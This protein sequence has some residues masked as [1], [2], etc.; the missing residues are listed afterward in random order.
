MSHKLLLRIILPLVTL[1]FVSCGGGGGDGDSESSSS[2]GCGTLNLKVINGEACSFGS[3]SPVALLVSQ[4]DANTVEVCTG[5][6]IT[7]TRV[8]TAAHC[9]ED[10]SSSQVVVGG[11]TYTFSKRTSHPL[12]D[13]AAGSP[14]DIAIGALPHAITTAVPVPIIT[15]TF[16]PSGSSLTVYGF[17]KTEKGDN[18]FSRDNPLFAASIDVITASDAG[19]LSA[20]DATNTSVCVGDS[21]GPALYN[22]G[23]GVGVAGVTTAVTADSETEEPTCKGGTESL[24][25]SVRRSENIAFIRA[26]ASGVVEK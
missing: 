20:F 11:Q 3:T 5:T 10:S 4:V 25:A 1:S 13:G 6:L 9:F 21:G 16:P 7:P 8:L 15:S 14:F 12:Y 18:V 19:I 23:A 22:P 24:F 17:G 26:N 2:G